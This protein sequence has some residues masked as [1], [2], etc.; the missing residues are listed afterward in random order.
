MPFPFV[1][2]TT[3]AFSF[4][5]SITSNS[6]P[7]LP[8]QASTRRGVVRDTLKKYK[9]VPP[10]SQAS[11]LPNVISSLRSYIPYL[12]ALHAGLTHHPV[13]GEDVS[14]IVN[15]P[16]QI[17]WRPTLSRNTI[18]GREPPRVKIQS[19][20]QELL[21]TLATLANA[22]TLQARAALHPLYQTTTAPPTPEQRTNAI[23][24]ATRHLLDAASIFDYLSQQQGLHQ[25]E[26]PP[27]CPE[28]HPS[29]LLAQRSLA[30]AEAT[31]LA[32]A[33]DDPYPAVVALA[34]NPHDKEWM[35]KA[36]DIPKV[37][38]HLFARLCLA[39]AEHATRA[40]GCI[41][42]IKG[43]VSEEFVKYLEDLRRTSRARACRF[44]AIDAELAGETA[45]GIAWLRAGLAELGIERKGDEAGKT[46]GLGL[47]GLKKEWSERRE[48][49]KVERGLDWGADAGRLE[50]RRV[51]EMLEG[52]WVKQND[53]VRCCP[54][55]H[56]SFHGRVADW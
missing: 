12:C 50:E 41:A 7:S 5:S 39:A 16:P 13:H 8:L 20:S 17:E 9:R 22:Y 40:M 51:I 37:R 48:D 4:P 46:G 26:S 55:S 33:K 47:K 28:I 29:F 42:S 27:P 1:L 38:V 32:V 31:L 35:F 45:T 44:F 11:S 36:P 56:L 52:K 25:A 24:T 49:K 14:L 23:T 30:L 18:P 15:S 2:P 19:L 43:T 53:M 6:H 21:F 10:A 3:S 54:P 34:R